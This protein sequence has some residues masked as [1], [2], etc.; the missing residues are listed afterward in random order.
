MQSTRINSQQTQQCHALRQYMSSWRWKLFQGSFIYVLYC[1]APTHT[2]STS[3]LA[4]SNI[5]SKIKR[6]SLP[7]FKVSVFL[8][9]Q[10]CRHHSAQVTRISRTLILFRPISFD[11]SVG[12]RCSGYTYTVPCRYH[13]RGG[14]QA[15]VAPSPPARP[16]TYILI[17]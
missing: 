7:S 1:L 13:Y 10:A 2:L 4:L 14:A 15:P 6:I 8:I 12:S 3:H 9:P 11:R 16:S 5:F 17:D